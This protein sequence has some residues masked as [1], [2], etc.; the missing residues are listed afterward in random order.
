MAEEAQ[1][2]KEHLGRVNEEKQVLSEKLQ[3]SNE[4]LIEKSAQL[5]TCES[6]L[7]GKNGEIKE[8]TTTLQTLKRVRPS[9]S[10]TRFSPTEASSSGFGS[11]VGVDGATG[12]ATRFGSG[13]GSPV[14]FGGQGW[15][16]PEVGEDDPKQG[17]R[18]TNRGNRR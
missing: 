9:T 1:R 4:K 12:M 13:G 3:T 6:S 15:N 10:M 17:K 5:D 16:V 14:G 7:R 2:L 8:L 11:M 18:P